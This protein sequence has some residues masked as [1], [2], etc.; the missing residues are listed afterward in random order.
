MFVVQAHSFRQQSRLA[1]TLAWVA[2]YTNI[3]AILTCGH[4]T[5]HV[6]GTTSD[7]GRWVAEGLRGGTEVW[8]LAGF[9]LFLL[10]MFMAGAMLSGLAT[11]TGR[12]RGW[13][14]IYVLPM[15]IEAVLLAA[16]A[17]GVELHEKTGPETGR[18]LYFMT[19]AA[20]MAMGV[21]NATITRI[22]AGGVRTTHVTGVLTDLG[23]EVAHLLASLGQRLTKAR[24]TTAV[25]ASVHHQADRLHELQ[26]FVSAERASATRLVLLA[27][28][29]ASFALGAGLGTLMFDWS[30]Q[31]AMVPPVLFLAWIIGQDLVRPIAEIQPSTLVDV[32]LGLD[33]RLV[34]YH[35][36][37]ERAPRGGT[38][39]I[40]RMPN[41]L[42]WSERLPTRAK[43]IVLDLEGVA[44]IDANSALE[45]RALLAAMRQSGRRLLLA[46]L[47]TQQV[48]QLRQSGVGEL[49]DPATACP[50]LELAIARGLA[51]LA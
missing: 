47:S 37:R 32:S 15:A 40:H 18:M 43:V 11:E 48:M 12:Q 19:G 23:L 7:L 26:N 20:S 25:G 46:G 35:V 28:I 21:Q 30:H 2:G 1:I 39:A 51:M 24:S 9:A 38:K 31:V 6:S 42:A 16:F 50:D 45:L 41:L 14:S 33:D 29:V 5:S 8:P 49:L 44:H 13:D 4:V 22:S 17:V 3:V 34:V 10:T 27:S 36:R